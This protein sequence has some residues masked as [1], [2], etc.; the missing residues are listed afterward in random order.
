M[1][2]VPF[3]PFKICQQKLSM[4]T[5]LSLVEREWEQSGGGNGNK[6]GETRES[7]G[8]RGTWWGRLGRVEGG[9]EQ[10]GGD[11]GEWKGEGNVV[12]ETRESESPIKKHKINPPF[13]IETP[14][15]KHLAEFPDEAFVGQTSQVQG[16]KMLST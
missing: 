16:G 9:W 15:R 14:D 3:L 13:V 4:S 12:G 11:Q 10:T 2:A 7:R 6:V 1:H 8:G 5:K